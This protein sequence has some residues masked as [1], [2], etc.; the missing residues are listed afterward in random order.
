[1]I[2]MYFLYSED[3][4]ES[5]YAIWKIVLRADFLAP[6]VEKEL[7][8]EYQFCTI[9]DLFSQNDDN[10]SGKCDDID[11]YKRFLIKDLENFN[12]NP[13]DEF[14]FGGYPHK[15]DKIEIDFFIKNRMKKQAGYFYPKIYDKE[16]KKELPAYY[17]V[18]SD[19]IEGEEKRTFRGLE[20]PETKAEIESLLF[21]NQFYRVKSGYDR[22]GILKFDYPYNLIYSNIQKIIIS[23][24]KNESFNIADFNKCF[25]EITEIEDFGVQKYLIY[26]LKSFAKELEYKKLFKSCNN[27]NKLFQFI[28]NKKY[29]SESCKIKIKNKKQYQRRKIKSNK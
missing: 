2:N 12:E 6:I 21:E 26:I 14:Y 7:I 29:C 23:Y 11:D 27:C 10:K 13:P 16:T 15:L 17:I 24:F 4:F 25:E 20:I 8:F 1:M 3:V 9:I 28:E 18:L 22:D 5:K 19:F